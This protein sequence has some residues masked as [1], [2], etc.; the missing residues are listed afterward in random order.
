MSEYVRMFHVSPCFECRGAFDA[1]VCSVPV[2]ACC[3][4]VG[5]S[6]STVLHEDAPDGATTNGEERVLHAALRVF[7][8]RPRAACH[9]TFDACGRRVPVRALVLVLLALAGCRREAPPAPLPAPLARVGAT[10]ITAADVVDEARRLR[11]SGQSVA[12]AQTVLQALVLRAAML[13]AAS[14]SSW[15]TAREARR[16]RENLLLSQWLE[17]TMQAEKEKVAISDDELRAFY[18]AHAEEFARPAMVRLAILHRKPAARGNDS[19]AEALRAALR[20]ARQAYLDAPA[21]ATRDGRIPGFGALAAEASEHATSRYRGGDIGWIETGR[22]AYPLPAAIVETGFA[23]PVG[24]VSDVIETE[25]GLYVVMKQDQREARTAPFEEVA[26]TQRRR[27]LRDKR[28][29]VE[30]AFK[31]NLLVRAAVAID[32]VQAAALTVP[33]APAPVGEPPALVPLT[34]FNRSD[35][36]VKAVSNTVPG[37]AETE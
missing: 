11:E 28:D 3:A 27:L 36:T 12:D 20:Q 30:A 2:R 1:R 37:K 13:Q 9:G 35:K 6:A 18:D 10:V 16:E 14:T 5:A 15:V 22:D 26:D 8:A 7:K 34:S 32:A 4:A 17:H 31:S 21:Q 25:E 33:E 19:A 23:L 24:G 29:R